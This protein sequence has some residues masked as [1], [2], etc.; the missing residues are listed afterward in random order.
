MIPIE[1]PK[2][3]I[4]K[5]R[6]FLIASSGVNGGYNFIPTTRG[7]REEGC[8]LS[9]LF[10]PERLE[11]Q[12]DQDS[13][14]RAAKRLFNKEFFITQLRWYGVP[15]KSNAKRDE[16][17]A[18]LRTAVGE[19]KCRCVP[20][21]VLAL[22][23]SMREDE[24]FCE[25]LRVYTTKMAEINAIKKKW[26]DEEWA[27][28]TPTERAEY[29]PEGFF[30]HYFLDEQGETDRTKTLEPMALHETSECEDMCEMAKAIPG[31]EADIMIREGPCDDFSLCET[32]CIGWDRD[33]VHALA[34]RISQEPRMYSVDQEGEEEDYEDDEGKEDLDM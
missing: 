2:R 8:R 22:E 12:Q 25:D 9:E 19:G 1:E 11:R 29:H 18:I 6:G 26:E 21:C 5:K 32:L 13:A 3:P 4:M 10:F 17:E 20:E 27:K 30:E 31:L 15:F 28:L 24:T 7:L 14:R 23:R 34:Q 16:L 33:A